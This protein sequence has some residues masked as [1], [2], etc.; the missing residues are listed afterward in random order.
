MTG[1]SMEY[2]SQQR[3]LKFD[4]RTINVLAF[5]VLVSAYKCLN[6]TAFSSVL[7]KCLM[8]C[9]GL[10]NYIV[11]KCNVGVKHVKHASL[12]RLGVISNKLVH[13]FVSSCLGNLPT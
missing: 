3:T 4:E 1:G 5:S 13:S 12:K 8:N 7:C 2:D 6:S 9:N 11:E 10:K